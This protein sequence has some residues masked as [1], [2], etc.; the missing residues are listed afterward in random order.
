MDARVYIASDH[1]GFALKSALVDDLRARGIAVE[2]MGAH[3]LDEGDDYP[4]FVTPCATR[5][6]EE[7]EKSARGGG[8]AAGVFGIVIGAS[9]EGEAMAANRTP[10]IRAAVYYGA[11]GSQTDASGETLD[12]IASVR[13]HNDANIL[14]LGARFLSVDDALDAVRRFLETPF[15]AAPRHVRRLAKF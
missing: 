4:D 15:S 12:L 11:A 6:A 5:V 10:G 8:A 2:D 3:T 7:Q 1:A 14:S 9:G 13:A